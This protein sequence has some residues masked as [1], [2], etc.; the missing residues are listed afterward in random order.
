MTPFL[1]LDCS[2]CHAAGCDKSKQCLRFLARYDVG[3]AT[4]WAERLCSDQLENFR[5][6]RHD[7]H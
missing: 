7:N 2:R 5:P 6:I 1:P 3:P 4:P